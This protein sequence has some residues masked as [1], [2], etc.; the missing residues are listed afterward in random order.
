MLSK[1][2]VPVF[3]E[4]APLKEQVK[5][6][7]EYVYTLTEELEYLLEHLDASNLNSG[8]L[9]LKGDETITVIGEKGTD[10]H[11]VGNI[12]INGEAIG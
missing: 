9:H 4:A 1:E 5:Q 6:L 3:D 12:Y 11:L 8:R 10:L 2:N 7:R